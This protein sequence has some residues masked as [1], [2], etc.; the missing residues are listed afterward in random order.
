MVNKFLIV[1]K[2][3]LPDVFDKVIEARNLI[4]NGSV[5]GIS[6][7]VKQVGISRSTYYKY[8]DYVFSPNEN[9]IGRKA[10]MSMMLKHEKGVLSNV[11]NYMSSEKINILTINQSL[12]INAKAAVMVSVDISD[13]D[14]SI[15]DIILSMK[16]LRGVSSVKLISIE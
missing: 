9:S 3:I 8:K 13:I 15:D 7:A 14:K 2:E 11:L 12:P 10:V 4:N 5:K 16:K 6:E 1:S